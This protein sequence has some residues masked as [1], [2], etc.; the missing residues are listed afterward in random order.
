V[1][2]GDITYLDVEHSVAAGRPVVVVAGTGR[3]A[4]ALARAVAGS[5]TASDGRAAR[6]ARSGLV[7]AVQL[8]VPEGVARAVD[9]ALSEVPGGTVAAPP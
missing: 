5:P 8:E 7:T 9:A 1:N 6:I 3:T 2:G 4:D